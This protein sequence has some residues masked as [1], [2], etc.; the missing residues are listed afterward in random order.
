ML[1]VLNI[2]ATSGYEKYNYGSTDHTDY[3][4]GEICILAPYELKTCDYF[5]I[6]CSWWYDGLR[7]VVTKV[8]D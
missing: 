2:S 6:L 1:D 5:I 3:L 7:V 8:F 4:P